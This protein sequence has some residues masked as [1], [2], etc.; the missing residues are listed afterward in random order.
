MNRAEGERKSASRGY[1]HHKFLTN[2]KNFWKTLEFLNIHGDSAGDN[3]L[4]A[5]AH[6]FNDFFVKK[7]PPVN[8]DLNFINDAYSDKALPII[9]EKSIFSAVS[10]LRKLMEVISTNKVQSKG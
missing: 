9:N 3:S 1:L 10:S 6:E 7:L 8:I 5:D 2:P 4:P